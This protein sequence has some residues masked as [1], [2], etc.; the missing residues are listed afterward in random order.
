LNLPALAIE[1]D[2]GTN[3]EP[4]S[5][6]FPRTVRMAIGSEQSVPSARASRGS[7]PIPLNVTTTAGFLGRTER[8][9]TNE[10]FPNTA[11]TS[12]GIS[13][14]APFRMP[15]TISFCMAAAM[16]SSFV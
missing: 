3:S 4:L 16:P 7:Y 10:A 2:R 1:R 14:M 13:P 12:A 15:C 11:V 8:G 5:Y 6:G 9:P